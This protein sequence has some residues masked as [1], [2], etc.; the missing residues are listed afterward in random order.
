MRWQNTAIQLKLTTVIVQVE[1]GKVEIFNDPFQAETIRLDPEP[2][3][4]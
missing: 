2:G 3:A 4:H 1:L